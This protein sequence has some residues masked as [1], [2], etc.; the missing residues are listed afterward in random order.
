[1]TVS[2]SRKTA[3]T[4]LAQGVILGVLVLCA[5]AA[6]TTGVWAQ[7]TAP[8]DSMTTAEADTTASA[9]LGSR[10]CVTGST[11]AKTGVAPT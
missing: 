11:S 4:A 7:D 6:W 10:F 1:M 8:A 3:P 2:R 9:A 5:G